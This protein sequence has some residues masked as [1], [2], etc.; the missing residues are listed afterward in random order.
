[1][2]SVPIL[3][4]TGLYSYD[5][6]AHLVDDLLDRSDQNRSHALFLV[7]HDTLDNINNMFGREADDAVIAHTT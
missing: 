1:M 7:D 2:A 3:S 6:S 5:T 4:I